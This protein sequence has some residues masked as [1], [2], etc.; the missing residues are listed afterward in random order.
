MEQVF[1]DNFDGFVMLPGG[2]AELS[3]GEPFKDT[4]CCVLAN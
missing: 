2:I 3:L 1:F 4:L